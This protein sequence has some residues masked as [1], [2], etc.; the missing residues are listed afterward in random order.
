MM[1]DGAVYILL[2]I[3]FLFCLLLFSSDNGEEK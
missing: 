1:E 2:G 3:G